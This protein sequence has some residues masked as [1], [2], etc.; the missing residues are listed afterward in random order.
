M[1][2]LILKITLQF[3]TITFKYIFTG[4]IHINANKYNILLQK[5][6]AHFNEIKKIKQKYKELSPDFEEYKK[7]REK[8]STFLK[9]YL[10]HHLGIIRYFNNLASIL[11]CYVSI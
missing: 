7:Q 3:V 11:T 1:Y 10:H 9:L 6:E 8:S 2:Y 5:I 4:L